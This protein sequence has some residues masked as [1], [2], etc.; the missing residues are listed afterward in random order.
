MIFAFQLWVTASDS[1]REPNIPSMVNNSLLHVL[2][3]E[4]YPVNNIFKVE[5]SKQMH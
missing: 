2:V 3:P 4:A 5:C 1:L